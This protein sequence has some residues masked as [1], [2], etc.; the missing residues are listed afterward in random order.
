MGAGSSR[1][2]GTEMKR[3]KNK[4]HTHTHVHTTHNTRRNPSKLTKETLRSANTI[5]T[6]KLN[7]QQRTKTVKSNQIVAKTTVSQ[8]PRHG[9]KY[10]RSEFVNGKMQNARLQNFKTVLTSEHTTGRCNVP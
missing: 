1:N 2:P 10:Q 3:N 8:A 5:L 4:P 6:S 7:S 9:R